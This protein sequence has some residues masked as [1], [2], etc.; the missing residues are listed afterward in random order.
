[1][2]VSGPRTIVPATRTAPA[3]TGKSPLVIFKSVLLPQPLRPTTVTNSPSETW[4]ETSSSATTSSSPIVDFPDSV[5]FDKV[6][7]AGP[8]HPR[9]L[10]DELI[11]VSR[12]I[13]DRRRQLKV[14]VSDLHRLFHHCL[15]HIAETLFLGLLIDNIVESCFH[16]RQA[17]LAVFLRIGLHENLKG[18]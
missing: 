11:D 6:C 13:V 18:L 15:F 7:Q 4:K 17:Y 1:M 3:V 10:A 2:F 8:L 5:V 12:L 14:L 9:V 16:L